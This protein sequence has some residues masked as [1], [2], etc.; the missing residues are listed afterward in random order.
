MRVSVIMPSYLG[1]YEGC[2]TDREEK[3]IRAVNSFISNDF[4][5]K[6]LIVIGDCCERTDYLLKHEFPMELECE[7]I[8]F[9][10]MSKKQPLFSGS[11]R[12][13]GLEMA[14]GD[15]IMYLDSDDM[16]GVHHIST[17]E[18]QM[19]FSN[20]DWCFY[21][22]FVAT[23]NGLATKHV[24]LVAGSA[25]TSSIAHLRSMKVDWDGC[26]GYGHDF[27]FIE[28]LMKKSSKYGRVFGASYIIC[29]IPNALDN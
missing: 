5:G 25:G 29:H 6:E 18:E 16:F 1:F 11:L 28:R 24:E 3:F 8:R 2:A 27:K 9:Y 4:V 14:K 21:S 22:D 26:N 19:R 23:E 20:F 10:N 15:I 17:V 13:K 7:I 12:S